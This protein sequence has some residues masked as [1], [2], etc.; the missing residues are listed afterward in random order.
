MERLVYQ[1]KHPGFE[2]ELE[3]RLTVEAAYQFA[4]SYPLS[5]ITM[6]APYRCQVDKIRALLDRDALSK[7]LGDEIS[8]KEWENFVHNR[9]S[10]VDSFQ[11]GESDAV[12]ICYVRSSAAGS[13]GFVDDP[14]RINV[15][16]TRCRREMLIIGDLEHLKKR[17]R[18]RIF[19]RME[20]AVERDGEIIT[21][22]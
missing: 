8:D 15:A 14:N 19:H 7:A 9:I 2:N 4:E 6:I 5:E 16:H 11:G 1:G 17:C 3:A 12:I 18:N 22:L 20:R 10:T 21:S 13:I